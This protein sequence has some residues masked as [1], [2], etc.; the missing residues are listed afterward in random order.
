M[1][2]VPPGHGES[3]ISYAATVTGADMRTLKGWREWLNL[4][5]PVTI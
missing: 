3:G 4:D 5:I 2:L 1:S